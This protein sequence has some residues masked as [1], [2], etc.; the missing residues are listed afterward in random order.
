MNT[1]SLQQCLCGTDLY[2]LDQILRGNI[3]SG[4]T[5]VDAGCGAG[6]NLQFLLQAGCTVYAIDANPQAIAQVRELAARVAPQ[7][8]AQN[9]VPGAVEAM[10]FAD[11]LADVAVC[12]AVLHFARD[13]RHFD[14]MLGELWR[15][16]KPGG[17]LFCRLASRIG[18]SFGRVR[19][20]VYRVGGAE[21][22]LV[23]EPMLMERTA[24]LGGTLED[25]LK[26]TIVQNARC[27]TTWVMRKPL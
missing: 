8:P 23:D 20:H 24:R 9:F 16:L 26:T 4:M 22:F 10:P 17:L 27:M 25:P 7:M 2:L 12:S 14:A 11:A 1:V 18:M 15:V 3:V 19:D 6:R 13:E 5:V 21:W